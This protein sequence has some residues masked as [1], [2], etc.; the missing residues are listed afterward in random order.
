MIWPSWALRRARQNWHTPTDALL[1]RAFSG[2][3]PSAGCCRA[4]HR[5]IRWRGWCRRGRASRAVRCSW[6]TASR[7]GSW[8]SSGSACSR[9]CRRLRRPPGLRQSHPGARHPVL[10]ALRSRR[11][12]RSHPW[13]FRCTSGRRGRFFPAA[14]HIRRAPCPAALHHRAR[15][16]AWR[17]PRPASA[18]HS[19]WRDRSPC[20]WRTVPRPSPVASRTR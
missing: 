9:P 3:R 15:S 19:R 18:R 1:P 5:Q 11:I 20:T 12:G 17:C 14:Q 7:A 4:W 13:R 2:C 10:P 16:C 6:Q 8:E